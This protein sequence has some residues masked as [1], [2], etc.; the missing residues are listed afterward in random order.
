MIMTDLMEQ[1]EQA[2]L[3]ADRVTAK[4]L[5]S[6]SDKSPSSI[7]VI[8]AAIV[9]VMEHIGSEWEKG[10]VSLSQ[11]YMSARIC[12]EL[13]DTITPSFDQS[14]ENHPPIAIAVLEDYHILGKKIVSAVLRASGFYFIDYHRVSVNELLRK[15]NKDKIEILLLSVL[16]FPSALKIKKLINEIKKQKS[17]P[18]IIVGGA[19]FRLDDQLWQQVGA[20]AMGRSASD[21]VHLILNMIDEIS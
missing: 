2:L 4:D 14:P 6:R 8:D 13:S 9:P 12:E 18:K 20:D 21:A 1:F 10:N 15:L 3:S 16:M 11:V 19:P 17:L 7:G 5:F